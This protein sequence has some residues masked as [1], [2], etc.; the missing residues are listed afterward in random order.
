MIDVR[1]H[2][3]SNCG[4]PYSKTVPEAKR[5]NIGGFPSQS[6]GFIGRPLLV[7]H[8]HYTAPGRLSFEFFQIE[9]FRIY[10]F[11]RKLFHFQ[12]Y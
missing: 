1:V 12:N 6:H 4:D 2:I 10:R 9:F 7:Q 3:R 11:C 8:M 5:M